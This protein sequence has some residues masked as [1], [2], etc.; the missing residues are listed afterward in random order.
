MKKLVNKKWFCL[1]FCFVVSSLIILFTS[2]CS[3]LY[4]FNDWV[5]ANAFFTTGQG[6]FN[7][8]V[9]YRDLFEQKGL[10]LY[11]IYGIGYLISHTSF[12]GIYFFEV[13]FWSIEIDGDKPSILSTSG[14]SICPRNCLAYDERLSKYL[15]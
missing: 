10:L 12:I 1:L 6:I 13:I 8:I 5:D 11:F 2:K 9:P 4:P 7:G 3:P 15:L 14:F